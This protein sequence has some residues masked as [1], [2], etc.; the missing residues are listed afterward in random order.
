MTDSNKPNMEE[1]FE[2][3]WLEEI[4]GERAMAW[5]EECN[6]ETL[7]RLSDDPRFEAARRA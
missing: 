3:A 7:V 6:R 4:H 5:V 2:F 1:P